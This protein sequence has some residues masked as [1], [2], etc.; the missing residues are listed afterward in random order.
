MPQ[1]DI[2][3]MVAWVN[4]GAPE[5]NPKDLPKPLLFV[6]GW[7]IGKPDLTVTMP[8]KFD[9]PATGTIDYQYLLIPLNLTEDKW[10]RPP[11][12]APAIAPSSTTSSRS[13]ARQ[14]PDG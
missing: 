3:T 6:N 7:N 13:F 10:S 12:S 4:A 9:V 11:K 1:R 14:I 2:D 8:S 5:G